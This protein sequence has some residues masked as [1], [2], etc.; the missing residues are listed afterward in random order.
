MIRSLEEA[1]NW[2]LAVKTLAGDMKKLA[3]K[4]DDPALEQVLSRDNRLRERTA[5]EMITKATTIL[6]DLDDLAILLL[7]SVF[8]ATIRDL[9][10]ADVDRETAELRHPA[11]LS[12]VKNL[13]DSI[14][15]GSFSKVTD[16]YKSRDVDLTAQVDQVRKFRNWVAHGRRDEPENSIDPER[17]IDRLQR[18][19]ARFA[20][21]EER[22]GISLPPIE[23][24]PELPPNP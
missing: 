18:Y 10:L 7:F 24:G 2:Y 6:D 9:A 12:A 16:A 8:E 14:K 22:G 15:N 3:G 21:T 11:V 13:K 1:Q 5:S 19:L 20:E 4:W 23:P 17:A